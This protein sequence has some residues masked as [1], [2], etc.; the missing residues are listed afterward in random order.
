MRHPHKMLLTM[1]DRLTGRRWQVPVSG[2]LSS[3]F[4]VPSVPSLKLLR[5]LSMTVDGRI[6]PYHERGHCQSAQS[7]PAACIGDSRLGDNLG[8]GVFDALTRAASRRDESLSAVVRR[9]LGKAVTPRREEPP[10]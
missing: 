1:E 4:I 3:S 6:L 8:A 2:S 5:P 7:G 10:R 9:V